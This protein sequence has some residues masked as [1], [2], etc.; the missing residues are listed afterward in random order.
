MA[1]Q[2][3][4]GFSDLADEERDRRT[5]TELIDSIERVRAS[6]NAQTLGTT[7]PLQMQVLLVLRNKGV[8]TA[9]T[10]AQVL[11][12]QRPNVSR[13]FGG[14]EKDGLIRPAENKD[15]PESHRGDSRKKFMV[16]SNNGIIRTN[17]YLAR[18]AIVQSARRTLAPPS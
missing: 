14:L 11:G 6:F 12:V 10:C 17:H 15:I 18:L 2:S 1:D 16:I 9:T 7:D 4:T 5:I 13:A 8:Q 3:L